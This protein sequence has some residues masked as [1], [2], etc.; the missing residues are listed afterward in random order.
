MVHKCN[1]I[2][3][4][5]S[6]EIAVCFAHNRKLLASFVLAFVL[7]SCGP[8]SGAPSCVEA[9]QWGAT[10]S[11][12][13]KVP[14]NQEFTYAGI[15]AKAGSYI[16]VKISG[17]I[18]LCSGNHVFKSGAYN[19]LDENGNP[20]TR[21][22]GIDAAN[23]EWQPASYQSI[24]P[25]GP[26]RYVQVKKGDKISI[27]ING[28][29]RDIDGIQTKGRGLYAYIVPV[30]ADPLNPTNPNDASQDSSKK[31]WYG[32]DGAGSSVTADNRKAD[33]DINYPEF[34]ELFDNGASGEGGG[35]YS[36][37]APRDGILW[38]KY[39]RTASARGIVDIGG[40]RYSPWRGIYAWQNNRKCLDCELITINATCATI[41]SAAFFAGPAV[42][43]GCVTSWISTCAA[44]GRL[45]QVAGLEDKFGRNC[46]EFATSATHYGL[47][48]GDHWIG[49]AYDGSEGDAYAGRNANSGGYEITIVSGCLGTFGEYMEMYVGTATGT[50]QKVTSPD[51]CTSG[52]PGCVDVMDGW[53]GTPVYY[54]KFT[55]LPASRVG[56]ENNMDMR[57]PSAG[58]W[59]PYYYVPP[60]PPSTL[61]TGLPPYKRAGKYSMPGT[62]VGF[63][64]G[65]PTTGEL[66]FRI[67]DKESSANH[68]NPGYYGD[69]FG[70][71]K[72]KI[73]TEKVDSSFSDFLQKIINPIK[74]LLF[75]YCRTSAFTGTVA[76]P[77]NYF[78]EMSQLDYR[79][80]EAGCEGLTYT[81]YY[82]VSVPAWQNGLSKRMYN[83]L[84]GGTAGLNGVFN[85]FIETLR[86]V[87]VLYVALYGMF[88]MLGMVSDD[89]GDFVKRIIQVSIVSVL[90]T[91]NSWEFFNEYFFHLFTKGV[92]DLIAI[93]TSDF[94]GSAEILYNTAGAGLNQLDASYNYNTPANLNLPV[95]HP[96]TVS[97][98]TQRIFNIFTFADVTIDMLF[99]QATWIKI[100]GLLF[101][102][103][104]G[105]IYI[106]LILMGMYMFIMVVFKA[107]VLYLL[108]M[109]AIALLLIVAPIFLIFMLFS[110]TRP[111]FDGWI[112]NLMVYTLQPVMVITA[113]AIFNIFFYAA[114]HKLL[115]YRVCWQSV[116][117]GEL[118]IGLI[119]IDFPLFNFYL[120]SLGAGS[121][122]TA[123]EMP[124]EF[125]MMFIYIIICSA[126]SKFVD[127]MADLSSEVILSSK[128]ASLSVAASKTLNNA[129]SLGNKGLGIGGAI[130]GASERIG[131]MVSRSGVNK[132]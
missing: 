19:L 87:L 71:Y 26:L 94:T 40:K 107:L 2:Y 57:G 31:T 14:A 95:G 24:S 48:R 82:G 35:G 125:F 7:S 32:V 115:F 63:P 116:F 4:R 129:L 90:L 60:V 109:I 55:L 38:F 16:D 84:V 123:L 110:R 83:I 12:E 18:D 126:L 59:H 17:L 73:E 91:P 69:N 42:F 105:F 113:L 101:N 68:P 13:I 11:I 61:G 132:K 81:N 74:G 120:P 25:P 9:H 20:I 51:G 54:E 34:F 108:A 44:K 6:Q 97:I 89:R 58:V 39:A 119:D 131:K 21:M 22:S 5:L 66:W 76:D 37:T 114:L 33:S 86:L 106:I 103:P 27:F 78:P 128:I 121:P 46:R 77:N 36:Y 62:G 79:I 70:A 28:N 56:P 85:P 43:T 104:I 30:G 75:G 122:A 53:S 41:A 29:Y 3:K 96:A 100:A 64:N 99:N 130:S 72:V 93:F 15:D 124:M 111:L 1:Y 117:S 92:D 45:Q 65:I 52:S 10:E 47:P 67:N 50:L 80:D 118:D 127:W 98:H 112:K 102:S 8:P 88:F 23:D 49:D